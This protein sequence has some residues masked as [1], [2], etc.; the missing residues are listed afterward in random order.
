MQTADEIDKLVNQASLRRSLSV[1]SF[2][3]RVAGPISATRIFLFPAEIA[4]LRSLLLA[5]ANVYRAFFEMSLS[6]R[7]ADDN[8]IPSPRGPA[9][10][11][12]RL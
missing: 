7:G 8:S 6:A 9:A 3:S 12:R 4:R 10:S 2:V 11:D 1:H 5:F